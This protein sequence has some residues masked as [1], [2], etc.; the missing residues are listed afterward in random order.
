MH[1]G[2]GT[3]AIPA[4]R[5]RPLLPAELR[6]REGKGRAAPVLRGPVA[7]APQTPMVL[8]DT[9]QARCGGEEAALSQVTGAPAL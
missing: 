3:P 8:Q 9:I 7:F 5:T 1:A 6:R 4:P 2:R